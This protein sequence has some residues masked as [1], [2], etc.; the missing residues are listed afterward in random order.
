[1]NTWIV[2]SVA[3]GLWLAATLLYLR[4]HITE[5]IRKRMLERKAMAAARV[6]QKAQAEGGAAPPGAQG[7]RLE[8]RL[9]EPGRE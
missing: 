1:V 6:R 5:A 2:A 8:L 3:I 4:R 9:R 7:P